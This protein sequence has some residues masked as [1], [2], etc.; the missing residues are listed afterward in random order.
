MF[1]HFSHC[2][3]GYQGVVGSCL[4]LEAASPMLTPLLIHSCVFLL[5]LLEERP[6]CFWM[7]QVLNKVN[8]SS[9]LVVI[10]GKA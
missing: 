9:S 1:R 3:A 2:S 8:G 7:Q 5:V 10:A 6:S 4:A